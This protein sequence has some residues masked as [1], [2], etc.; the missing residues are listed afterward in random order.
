[1]CK[2]T[3]VEKLLEDGKLNQDGFPQR[4]HNGPWFHCISMSH[5]NGFSHT[6]ID[7]FTYVQLHIATIC[8]NHCKFY[9]VVVL[10]L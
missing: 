8:I 1:M 10:K 4:F 7:T 6:L 5:F 3:K 9:I 2:K